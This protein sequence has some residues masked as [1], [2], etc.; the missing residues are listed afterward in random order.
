VLD[1]VGDRDEPS[2]RE[3]DVGAIVGNTENVLVSL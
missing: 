1:A 2:Q 3:L